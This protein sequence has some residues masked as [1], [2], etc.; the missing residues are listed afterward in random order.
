M[1][2]KFVEPLLL[3][4]L[5]LLSLWLFA[6][7]LVVVIAVVICHRGISLVPSPLLF[8]FRAEPDQPYTHPDHLSKAARLSW[9]SAATA[10]SVGMC[11]S[12]QS[13]GRSGQHGTWPCVYG[14]QFLTGTGVCHSFRLDVG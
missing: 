6:L 10:F 4:P 8:C 3:L 2:F 14:E 12:N 7:R 5:L 9:S 1:Y 11:S 13:R